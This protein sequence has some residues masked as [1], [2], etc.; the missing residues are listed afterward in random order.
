MEPEIITFQYRRKYSE[1]MR[2][3][4]ASAFQFVDD[5]PF[6]CS[7]AFSSQQQ[8]YNQSLVLPTL[9]TGDLAQILIMNVS[10]LAFLTG[11]ACQLASRH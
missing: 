11:Y 3:V 6:V 7:E 9:Y 8:R 10:W 2:Y 4:S 1:N 5:A